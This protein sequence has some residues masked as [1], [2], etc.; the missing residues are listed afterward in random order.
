MINEYSAE[1]ISF[2]DP[3]QTEEVV[4]EIERGILTLLS[5]IHRLGIDVLSGNRLR[6]DD[7]LM[8]IW[9]NFPAFSEGERFLQLIAENSEMLKN[10]ITGEEDS[11]AKS[12]DWSYQLEMEDYSDNDEPVIGASFTVSIPISDY[13]LVLDV[14]T[15]EVARKDLIPS[16]IYLEDGEIKNQNYPDTFYMPPKEERLGI[17]EGDEVKLI[18]CSNEGHAERIWVRVHK[19]FDEDGIASGMLAN[20]PVFLPISLGDEVKFRV[21]NIIEIN[22]I[23]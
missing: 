11:C 16:Q 5:Q 6:C 13:A 2:F 3:M 22:K 1:K 20:C 8:T 9:I 21:E 17:M 18:I 14:L 15:K 23:D 12:L 19:R 7:D 10:H 4:I